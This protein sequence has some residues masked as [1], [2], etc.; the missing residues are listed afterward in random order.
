MTVLP[1]KH[2]TEVDQPILGADIFNLAKLQRSGI[3]VVLGVAVS[4]PEIVLNVILKHIQGIKSEVFESRLELIK[5]DLAKISIP[6]EL[7]KETKNFKAFFI[8]G[9]IFKKKN[10][11]WKALLNIWIE[12]IKLKIWNN[13]LGNGVASNLSS[14]VIFNVHDSFSE[15]SAYFDP[16]LKEVIIK[17]PAKLPPPM[18][19]K[20]DQVVLDA[21]KKLFIPQVYR[22]LIIEGKPFIVSV[23]PFT[24]TLP[25]SKTED[26]VITKK[27]EVEL[28]KKAVKLFLNL[29][30]GFAVAHNIDGILIEGEKIKG[31]D[32]LVFQIGESALSFPGKPVIYKLPDI[33]DASKIRGTLRLINQTSILDETA[34][35][36]LFI[37]NKKSLYNLELGIPLT[38]TSG[39]LLQLKRELAVRG[40]SRKGVLRFWLECGVPENFINLEDYLTVGIDGI[41]L[42]LDELQKNLGGYEVSEGQFYKDHVQALVKFLKPAFKILHQSKIP[43][44]IKG[45]LALHHEILDFLVESGIW[46]VTV[47]TPLQAESVPEHLAWVERRMVSRR[48]I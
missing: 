10:D 32:N 16:D 48:L 36:F 14:Q 21:N 23:S 39:E 40:I 5:S 42:N 20:I 26:I 33:V 1:I 6:E 4:P 3:P 25:V 44:L 22:F 27:V 31:F 47:N 15:V 37:R 29:S 45:E 12:E 17:S 41:I 24:Q 28:C 43:V 38:R 18:L 46:G 8:Q 9:L 13:G 19:K 34:K 7:E 11:F 30:S 35:T 2:I